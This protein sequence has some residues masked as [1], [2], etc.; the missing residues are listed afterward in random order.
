MLPGLM[1]VVGPVKPV[2]MPPN[3]HVGSVRLLFQFPL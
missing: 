1:G 3:V 2:A